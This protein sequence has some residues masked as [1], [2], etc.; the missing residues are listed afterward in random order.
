MR[1]SDRWNIR[2][3]RCGKICVVDSDSHPVIRQGMIREGTGFAAPSHQTDQDGK[4]KS[5]NR[6][7]IMLAR[8]GNHESF[9]WKQGVVLALALLLGIVLA[10][11]IHA[12]DARHAAVAP[13]ALPTGID[14]WARPMPDQGAVTR[15]EPNNARSALWRILDLHQTEQHAAAIAAWNNVTLPHELAV[16]KWVA[17]D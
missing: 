12:A 1:A 9:T 14:E 3:I 4:W 17:T 10:A 15:S 16:W 8:S 2:T 7:C 6:R 11:V 5:M 13:Q